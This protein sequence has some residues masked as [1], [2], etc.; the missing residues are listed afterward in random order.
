LEERIKPEQLRDLTSDQKSSLRDKWTPGTYDVVWNE[1]EENTMV[2][3]FDF[4]SRKLI[5]METSMCEM[6]EQL[7]DKKEFLPLLSIG[8]MIEILSIEDRE[9]ME[10]IVKNSEFKEYCD[11]LWEAVKVIL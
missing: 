7:Y 2:V 5:D 1:W 6:G 8:Q 11:K 10:N 3:K 4:V 9:I